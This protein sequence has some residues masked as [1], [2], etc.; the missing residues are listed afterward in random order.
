M[1]HW[2]FEFILLQYVQKER[3][4]D[5]IKSIRQLNTFKCVLGLMPKSFF[6]WLQWVSKVGG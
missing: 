6:L 3:Y 5:E 1:Y 4:R 2:Y